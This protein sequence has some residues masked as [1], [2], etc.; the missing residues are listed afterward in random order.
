MRR[1]LSTCL[2]LWLALMVSAQAVTIERPLPDIAQ[3]TRAQALFHQLKCMVCE[4][5][6]LAESDA[7][8][9]VQMRAQI[10]QM[11]AH[12][13]ADAEVL[14]FFRARYGSQI[15]LTPP[16][17]TDTWALWLAPLVLLLG[18]AYAVRRVT[19]GSA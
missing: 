8:L 3:E 4:G 18:G 2:I 19:K 13:T 1:S 7:A 5:Q 12:D 15:L 14:A 17:E 6:A 16:L 10:R 11:V 9:A